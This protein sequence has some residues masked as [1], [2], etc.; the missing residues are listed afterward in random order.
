MSNYEN[1]VAI[2]RRDINSVNSAFKEF[3]ALSEKEFNIRSKSN[4]KLYKGISPTKLEEVT[5]DLLKDV[6]PRTPF[7]PEDIILVSGHSFPDIM[8]TGYCGVE[9]K[10]TKDDKWTSVGSSIV[11]STRNSTVENIYM[12]FGKLGGNPPEFKLRP[13]QECLCGIAVTHSPRYLIN[14]E[15]SEHD[16]IFYKMNKTYDSFRLLDEKEKISEVRKYYTQKA[17]SEKK[18]E[19][20]WWM[21]ETASINLAFYNDLSPIEK[22][23]MLTRCYIIFHSMYDS[24][25]QT[26]Y[27][28]IALWLC[29]H[30]SLLCPNM[31]DF[32][33]AGGVCLLKHKGV[34]REYPHIVG[35]V[36]ERVQIIKRLLDNP[37]VELIKDIEYFWDFIYD[38]NNLFESWLLMVE[39]SFRLNRKLNNIPIRDLIKERLREI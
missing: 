34:I 19:M 33:T 24:D 29:N 4:P 11:E 26:K 22:D 31:R 15:L 39:N 12:L 17:K 7:K 37:D 6:A 9:V 3:M 16:N 32:F 13:Y 18:N 1:V 28:G 8:A 20:P 36:I 23:K 21:G 2:N 10:S 27:K 35:E 14:M 38:R 30:Y 5:R 25:Q